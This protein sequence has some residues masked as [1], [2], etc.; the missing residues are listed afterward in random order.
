MVLKAAIDWLHGHGQQEYKPY[1]ISIYFK[2]LLISN[3]CLP[4]GVFV[5]FA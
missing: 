1:F 3:M 5:L 2:H 4:W